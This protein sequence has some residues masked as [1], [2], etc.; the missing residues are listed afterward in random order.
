MKSNN[1]KTKTPQMKPQ[2]QQIA[3]TNA[4]TKCKL[5]KKKQRTQN[6]NSN[7][8]HLL[9]LINESIN[10]SQNSNDNIN[11]IDKGW[12]IFFDSP[13]DNKR[14][15]FSKMYESLNRPK[16][17]TNH[18]AMFDDI[19]AVSESLQVLEDTIKLYGPGIPK[20]QHLNKVKLMAAH[21]TIENNK[22]KNH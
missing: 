11:N 8:T 2:T 22:Q 6:S 13:I 18:I 12:I 9:K 4:Y 17:S 3:Y 14:Y 7:N 20:H 10:N 1:P 19:I 5:K 16:F 21:A 15:Y